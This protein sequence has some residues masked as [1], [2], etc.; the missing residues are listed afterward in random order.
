MTIEEIRKTIDSERAILLPLWDLVT[1]PFFKEQCQR[2]LDDLDMLEYL[3]FDG[4][5]RPS[6]Q[7]V[8]WFLRI[9]V[10]RR[11]SVEDPVTKWGYNAVAIPYDLQRR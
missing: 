5:E 9:V 6:L 11:K 2:A 7:L 1:S 4:P 10:E 8:E 3:C